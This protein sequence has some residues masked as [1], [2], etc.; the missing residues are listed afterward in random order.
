MGLP[1]T[2]NWSLAYWVW[3]PSVTRVAVFMVRRRIE[4]RLPDM[5]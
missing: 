5:I 1:E 4:L 2:E 3:V